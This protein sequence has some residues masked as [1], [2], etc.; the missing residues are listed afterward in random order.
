MLTDILVLN[1]LAVTLVTGNSILG[2]GVRLAKMTLVQFCKKLRFSV[3]FYKINCGFVFFCTVCCL[4]CMHS[5]ECFLCWTGPTVS[6]SD[7]ELEVHRYGM[8]ESTLTVGPIM[9]EDKLWMRQN[10]KLSPNRR[11]GFFEDGTAETEFSVF[12]ILRSVRFGF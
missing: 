7:S 5:T 2:R 9:L 3:Q 6:W 4:L 11:C 12:W 8:K 10:E 1:T